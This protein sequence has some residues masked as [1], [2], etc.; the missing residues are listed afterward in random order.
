MSALFHVR[1]AAVSA[2]SATLQVRSIHP[3]SGPPSAMATFALMLLYDPI[4]NSGYSDFRK[5]NHLEASALARAMDRQDYLRSSWIRQN[6][7]AFVARAKVTQGALEIWPTHPAWIE[8]LRKGM[9]WETAAYSDGPGEPAEPRVPAPADAPVQSSRDPAAGFRVGAPKLDDCDVQEAFIPLH[10]ANH[11]VA[12]PVF[13]EPAAM[14]Q[15]VQTMLGQPL[16]VVPRRGPAET[17]AL[18]EVRP[19]GVYIYRE[20]EYGWGACTHNFDELSALGRAWLKLPQAAAKKA[21]KKA[22]KAAVKKAAVK[23]AAVKKAAVKKAAVKKAAVKKAAVKKAAV[24][25]AA[26][27]KAAVKKAAVK[28]AA[29]KKA[30]AKKAAA[31]KSGHARRSA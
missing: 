26:V 9:A 4:I 2:G 5:Y 25:K 20:S 21:V 7:R 8:H 30:A 31:K 16:L 29:V 15:A 12:D 18:V 14:K 28:K 19:S 3:D 1:V 17:G 27:K 10:G 6:A 13:T 24:K 11:Y 22:A 23:K